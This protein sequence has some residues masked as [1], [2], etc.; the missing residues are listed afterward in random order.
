VVNQ[1]SQNTNVVFMVDTSGSMKEEAVQL[2]TNLEGFV[3]RVKREAL[4]QQRI[5]F[6]VVG[7]EGNIFNS[8]TPLLPAPYK[9]N[10]LVDDVYWHHDLVFSADKFL[11][12]M[13]VFGL[14][15]YT[16]VGTTKPVSIN[17]T[18]YATIPGLNIAANSACKGTNL[19]D[20]DALNHIV[21]VTDDGESLAGC[22]ANTPNCIPDTFDNEMKAHLAKTDSSYR[23]HA[24]N[25]TK[26]SV[27]SSTCAAGVEG[28]WK[29]YES[30]AAESGGLSLDLCQNDWSPL[31]DQLK[32]R[33]VSTT[34][35]A[36]FGQCAKSDREIVSVALKLKDGLTITLTLK[37]VTYAAPAGTAAATI[38][39]P[40]S[41]LDSKGIAIDQVAGLVVQSKLK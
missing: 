15:A 29:D 41:F 3:T 8:K 35:P 26:T 34:R 18:K 38:Y 24:I 33:I 7:T 30:L 40:G 25:F 6:A 36:A 13:G 31:F 4:S 5:R 16:P 39:L 20:C 23:L 32:E 10:A 37:D 21:F 9:P 19:F 22:A 1:T 28:V 11:A 14:T 17:K 27:K 2:R 12:T